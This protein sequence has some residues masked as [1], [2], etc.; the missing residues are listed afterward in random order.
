MVRV[1]PTEE[2]GSVGLSIAKK[3]L[4]RATDRNL[5]KRIFREA[6]RARAAEFKQADILMMLM[7]KPD[8]KGA[9]SRAQLRFAADQALE[10]VQSRFQQS[11]LA[12]DR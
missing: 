9:Q 10:R 7:Q 8:L 12:T 11:T 2:S 5:V 3:L 4:K 1:L 6:Y